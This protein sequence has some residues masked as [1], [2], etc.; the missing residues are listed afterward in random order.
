MI[1]VIGSGPAGV[2]AAVALTRQGLP[3]TVLDVGLSL[4][5]ARAAAVGRLA[6]R[7]PQ[8]WAAADVATVRQHLTADA[9]GVPLKVSFGSDFVY[10]DAERHLP[11]RA[12]GVGVVPSFGEGGFG[13]V[14]GAA[15]LPY[16][17]DELDGW[18]LGPGELEGAFARV[19][20]FVGLSGADDDLAERFPAY[21]DRL[22]ALPASRQAEELLGDLRRHREA[23]RAQGFVFGRARLAVAGRNAGGHGCERCGLCMSGCPYGLIYNPAVTLRGLV[24]RG[25]VTYV[26]GVLVTGFAE[27]GGEVHIDVRQLA[28]GRTVRHVAS[29]LYVAGGVLGTTKLYLASIGAYDHELVVRDSQY[30]LLPMLRYSGVPGV[31][32]EGLHTLS[33]VFLEVFDPRLSARSIHLQLYTYNPLYRRAVEATLGAAYPALRPLSEALLRR[34]LLIQG[35][36]HSDLSG[37]I[38]LT[39]R[40]DG[41][42]DLEGRPGP[43]T[44]RVLGGLVAKLRRNRSSLRAVPLRPLLKLGEPGRG[45]HCG[46]SLPMRRRPGDF[47]TDP[48]GRPAGFERVHLV[49]ATVF[50]TVTASTITLT[51]MANAYRIGAHEDAGR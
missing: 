24:A 41:V 9:G 37:E 16:L 3:V 48:L 21:T 38:G 2:A 10:R 45:F 43:R 51:V 47:E 36:L 44:R 33:Q 42:L 14:W 4:E 1:Y 40:R 26:P 49:D 25:L 32:D 23:L 12:T 22:E 30:F 46:G 18:P 29:R 7:P 6:A 28:T 8:G 19:L 31:S 39:L 35:Y 27:R 11:R 13:N 20:S 17:R 50:P 15:A 5:P 34:M